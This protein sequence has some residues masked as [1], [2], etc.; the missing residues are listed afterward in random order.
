MSTDVGSYGAR[1]GVVESR[2]TVRV[3]ARQSAAVA[4][5]LSASLT[6]APVAAAAASAIKTHFWGRR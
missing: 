2:G 4:A 3:V 1:N 5:A 6:A